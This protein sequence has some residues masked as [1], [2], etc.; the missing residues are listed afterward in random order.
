MPAQENELFSKG[1]TSSALSS[2]KPISKLMLGIIICGV[3]PCSNSRAPTCLLGAV[4]TFFITMP[5]LAQTPDLVVYTYDSF[6]SEWGAGTGGL[7][8]L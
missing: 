3:F 7:Q 4:L 8:E 5:V 6:N 1:P 2:T